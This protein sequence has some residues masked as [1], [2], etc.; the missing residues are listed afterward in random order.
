MGFSFDGFVLRPPRIS[1]VNSKY[2]GEPDNGVIRVPMEVPPVYDISGTSPDFIDAYADQYRAAVLDGPGSSPQE[3]LF[4]AQN[5][6]QLAVADDPSW[7]TELGQGTFPAGS[8]SVLDTTPAPQKPPLKGAGWF[9]DGTSRVVVADDGGR[10]LGAILWLVVARGDV[11]DYDD[12]GWVDPDNPASPRAGDNPYLAFEIATGDQ[13]PVAGTADLTAA[14]LTLLDGG[15]SQERGD[16]IMGV[17]YTVGTVK[18]W[19]TR[20]DRYETRFGWSDTTQRWEPYKGS[21]PRDLGRLYLDQTYKMDPKVANLPVNSELPGTS[22]VDAY[23][24]IRLGPSPS[25][26]L[27]VEDIVVRPNTEVAGG[28]DFTAYP[29]F[30]AV[31]G[32]TNGILE[33]NP[34]FAEQHAGKTVWYCFKTFT[35][36]DEGLVGQL[37]DALTDPLFLSPIPGPT[38]RPL[39]RLGNR[40]Y[41][42]PTLLDT[43]AD[44]D[45]HGDPA[46]GEVSVSLS[47][48][49]IR[50]APGDMAKSDP[51]DAAAFDKHF[52]GEDVIYDGVALNQVPQ[53]TKAPVQLV[54]DAG[55][56]S[57]AG[58]GDLFIPL[59]VTLPNDNY[60]TD[61]TR[62]GLG[63]SGII[64]APDET[65][66]LPISPGTVPGIRPGGD[67]LTG[68]WTGMVRQVEDGVGDTIIF[69]T[70]SA[71]QILVVDREQDLPDRS[72]KVAKGTAYVSRQA[73]GAGTLSKVQ[74]S[75]DDLRDW[76]GEAVYFLQASLT[77]ATYTRLPRVLS[78]NRDLFRFD[79]TEILYFNVDT[80]DYT[81]LASALPAASF[82]TPDQVA[83]SINTAITGTGSAYALNGRLVIEGDDTVEIG[84]GTATDKDLSGAAILGFMPGWR[85]QGGTTNWLTDSGVS[86]GLNRSPVNMARTNATPDLAAS[87]RM[88]DRTLTKNIQ[89]TPFFFLDAPPLQDV[90][91]IDDGVF[92]NL[93]SMITEGE[94]VTIVNR[95][96]QH[97]SDIIHRFGQ[98]KFDWVD[99]DSIE[100]NVERSTSVLG[101]GFSN[102]VPESMLG[103][104]GIG[105]G[106]LIS[107]D[108]GPSVFQDSDTDYVL[109]D[110]GISGQAILVERFG[111]RAMSGAQG[112]MTA[113]STTFSD[114]DGDFTNVQPG[115]RLK[116]LS[117]DNAGS[118]VVAEVL[119]GTSLRVSP[120]AL[121]TTSTPVVWSLYEGYTRD[122]YDPSLAADFVYQT[123]NHLPEEPFQ[124]RLLSPLGDVPTDQ[125]N[126]RLKANMEGALESGRP[127]ELRYGLTVATSTNTASLTPLTQ[128]ELGP[129]ANNSLEVPD[130]GSTRFTTEK[131]SI[132]VGTESYYHGALLTGVAS[133]SADPGG[134]SGI[135]YLTAAGSDGDIGLLKFGSNVLVSYATA[136]VWYVEEFSDPSDLTALA[137]EYNPNTGYLN[138]PEADV[139]AWAGTRAYFVER[140]ITEGREDVSLSPQVGTFAFNSPV[141][142]GCAV[143][144]QYWRADLEGRKVGD[145]VVEFLPVP[146]RNEA[147]QRVSD[148]VFYFNTTQNT[149]LQAIDPI[150][151]LGPVQQNFG[152]QDCI[153]DFPT[154]MAGVGRITFLAQTIP[155]HVDVMVSYWVFEAQGGER[156]YETSQKP[157]YRPPFF[158]KE[159]LDRFGLRGDRTADFVAGQLLRFGEDCFYVRA[160]DYWP[161]DDI[162]GIDIFPSTVLEVGTRAPANDV[163][164][165]MT[166]DPVTTIVDPDG[167]T[168]VSTSAPAGFMFPVDLVTFPFEPVSKGQKAIT[169]TGDLTSFAIPGHIFEIGGYPFTISEVGLNDDGTRTKVS[170]TAGFQAAFDVSNSPTVKLSYR[171][172][173]APDTRDIL[174][175]GA[176]L[177]SEESELVVYGESSGGV[178]QPGRTLRPTVDYEIEPSTGNVKLLDPMQAALQPGQSLSLSYTQV[179]TL[180]PF[181]KDGVVAF[182]RY[183]ADFLHTI[184]PDESNGLLGG[185]VTGTYTFRSPDTF[186]FRILTLPS[187]LVEAAGEAVD[188]ITAKRPAGGAIQPPAGGDENWEKGRLGLAGER[189]HLMDKDRAARTFLDFYNSNI[190]A[191]E[192]VGETIN[193]E[194]VGD[195]DGKF[196]FFV[197]HGKDV[198]TPGYEN[199]ITG[200]LTPR[201]VWSEV[202]NEANP[203]LDLWFIED[204]YVVS[205]ASTTMVSGVLQ[206]WMPDS[207]DLEALMVR[208]GALVQNDV[209]DVVMTR[210]GKPDVK[211]IPGL[212]PRFFARA[213]GEFALMSDQH[214]FSRLYPTLTR[215]FML[216]GPGVGAD[217][218][219]GD[220]GVYTW[221]RLIDGEFRRSKGSTIAQ[222]YNPVVEDITGVST[223]SLSNRYARGRVWGYFPDGIPA[224]MFQSGGSLAM[225]QPCI[226][227]FPAP[228]G[229]V[230][231]DPQ[232]GYPDDTQL[233]SQGLGGE[234][235]D[236]ASG[237]PDLVVPGFL[238]GEQIRW[239]QPDGGLYE[240][241]YQ[242]AIDIFGQAVLTGVFVSQVLYGCVLTLADNTGEPITNSNRVLIGT[243]PDAGIPLHQFPVER[244]DT[245]Y[246]GPPLGSQ[247]A[248]PADPVTFETIQTMSEGF[249][250]FRDGFDFDVKE[251]GRIVDKTL[252]SFKDPWFFGLKEMFGQ[253]PPD[254]VSAIGGPVEF[255]YQSQ[256][257]LRV[258]ALNGADKDD[259]G[260]YQIP[261]LRSTN[262]ELDR[263]DELS[264]TMAAVVMTVDGAGNA[265]YPDEIV[266]NDG[267]VLTSPDLDPAMLGTGQ[268][269]QPLANGSLAKGIGD[270]HP[271]DLM[272]IQVDSPSPFGTGG[273][274][275]IH[276]V[277]SVAASAG[278]PSDLEPPRFVTPVARGQNVRHTMENA[279]VYLKG[280]YDGTPQTTLP[281]GC[282]ISQH[283]AS[284]A[285]IMD[286]ASVVAAGDALDLN[287]RL[288]PL[289]PNPLGNLNNIWW[290]DPNNRV[291][292]QLISR[293]DNTILNGPAGG[294]PD[295]WLNP[296]G[297]VALTIILTMT[298]VEVIDY[299]GTSTGP[300]ALG[301]PPES[302]TNFP[303]PNPLPEDNHEIIFYPAVGVIPWGPGGGGFNEWFL[304]YLGTPFYNRMIYGFEF[305]V[306]VDTAGLPMLAGEP[307]SIPPA[308]AGLSTSAA[309]RPDRLVFDESVDLRWAAP[310]GFQHPQSGLLLQTSLLINEVEINHPSGVHWSSINRFC[311]G[312]AGAG[313]GV[314]LT[315]LERGYGTGNWTPATLPG[316]DSGS[317]RAMSFEGYGDQAFTASDVR[318]SGVATNTNIKGGADICTGTGSICSP[319]SIPAISP[320]DVRAFSDRVAGITLGAGALSNIEQGDLLVIDSAPGANPA[321]TKVGTYLVRHAV[322]RD[323][324][325]APG[326]YWR[327]APEITVGGG[328]DWVPMVFPTV[329]AFTPGTLTLSN[330]PQTEYKDPAVV[331]LV[332]GLYWSAFPDS[333]GV[334]RIYIVRNVGDLASA[335]E[336]T[337]NHA[338][339]SAQYTAITLGGG[340]TPDFAVTDYRDASGN[341]LSPADFEALLDKPYPVSGM[342]YLPVNVNGPGLPDDNVA[343]Y[344]NPGAVNLGFEFITL[345]PPASLAAASDL[346]FSAPGGDIVTN[347]TAPNSVGVHEGWMDLTRWNEFDPEE[348]SVRFS[349]V[350]HTLDISSLLLLWPSINVPP[351]SFGFGGANVVGCILPGTTAGAAD[352]SVP[353][354]VTPGHY[355][356]EGIF[357]E[358]SFPRSTVD[359][360]AVDPLVVDSA[361]PLPNPHAQDD[362][363]R[364]VTAR[365]AYY[366]DLSGATVSDPELVSFE[367]R[368]MRRW[369]EIQEDAGSG[370]KPLRYAYEIR[371]GIL[372]GYSGSARQRPTVHAESFVMDWNDNPLHAPFDPKA[373]D[374]WN[375]GQTYTGTNVGPFTDP[376][377]NINA[378]D[379]FRLLGE[380]LSVLEEIEIVGVEGD[381][382]LKLVAP[383]QTSSPIGYRF[384]I[385]LRQAV[386]PHEQSNEQLLELITDRLVHQTDADWSTDAGGY[387]KNTG[388]YGTDANK[389][390]DSKEDLNT[391]GIRKDDI[392]IIDPQ[393]DLDVRGLGAT[394]LNEKGARPLGD[395]GVDGRTSGYD[396]LEPSVYDDNRGYYRVKS[397]IYDAV[398]PHL[399]LEPISTYSGTALTP[400]TFAD[401]DFEY[402]VYPTISGST[403][404]GTG[405]DEGQMDLRPTQARDPISKSFDGNQF[406]V[407]PFSYKVIR[408]SGLYTNEALD[409]VLMIRERMLSII[410]MFRA[411]LNGRK[412][413]NF[414]VFQRDEHI[415]DVGH[416]TD[417]EDGMGV[418]SNAY[419]QSLVGE[420]DFQPYLNNSGCLSM[421]DR[422]FWIHDSKLDSLT[423][424]GDGFSM[425]LLSQ[426]PPGP[427]APVPY[428]AY[429]DTSPGGGGE[430]LPVEPER[431]DLVLDTSDKFRPV[432]YVWLA[433]RTHKVLGTIASLRRFDEELPERLA[434]AERLILL[435]ETV[436]GVSDE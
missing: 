9:Y 172:I 371:R 78:R 174:G 312:N 432:R 268:D 143:E 260:D 180:Q 18:M 85:V 318:F 383:I 218:E 430:V 346:P 365:E 99:D 16:Q 83:A 421:L 436:E 178:T 128:A 254:P 424:V 90:A 189:R 79:G 272:L 41:L 428:T 410:E 296:G 72:Y 205:P 28:F 8:L 170:V 231:V 293:W 399:V 10:S 11:D 354:T 228:L 409:L 319:L 277:G 48:G 121:A 155:A 266:A 95:P 114:P 351:G 185:R 249:D 292:I 93:Q 270:V 367:I 69:A 295:P 59:A 377:V 287:D 146:V 419:L 407:Q 147:A 379:T 94:S 211:F 279:M 429:T 341:P 177:E 420:V 49:R 220:N 161:D 105:G 36:T 334:V 394:D 98:R 198:P 335:D 349:N 6:A 66:A 126:N 258:P 216:T 201:N 175:L 397:V 167:Q 14:Q 38:D 275:G 213:Q 207:D 107:P 137:A 246:V 97:Y 364:S 376:D 284:G 389:L 56:P 333:A 63:V 233:L 245:V 240:V 19:W 230:P 369:H 67:T 411:M 274:M 217:P 311:N 232:T 140:M 123:F 314:P 88:E 100:G 404:P 298:T 271:G 151:Y 301:F 329:E 200:A 302:G 1:P 366:Y 304:P 17:R 362:W 7:W 112:A 237:D 416:P 129:V 27:P 76:D 89:A 413:G 242:Q 310:R 150:V 182:P 115:Y 149:V 70:Q 179:R 62:R 171:P 350:V 385:Y 239:G 136:P 374:V 209:D 251:D 276:A 199:P 153:I 181:L 46:E 259:S 423:G 206:G 118:Y 264:G 158:I 212:P 226:V 64:N 360:G 142:E 15:L 12:E 80:V 2:T 43:D 347:G 53:P 65:G 168:P 297:F 330:L 221:G 134:G 173:Y 61:L 244:G 192:Q 81:W 392:V 372:T 326:P 54:D 359:L 223:A 116:V 307:I 23:A 267:T 368:R 339:I 403:L 42:T 380:D 86:L 434:E 252:P 82:Y 117:G 327:S 3:Y 208:Q 102:I 378:G 315:F 229:E 324:L 109:P 187:F 73:H 176:L 103:A 305:R 320:D 353:G 343:G 92:F 108:G 336:T 219:N 148:K 309:I 325:A 316:E 87:D 388:A 235:V 248:G 222:L 74:L 111:A 32:Q 214:R 241:Y 357:L 262:T 384:E 273:P 238:E 415:I 289:A 422:R 405:G 125:V 215:A 375:D 159:N 247:D 193:G 337:F 426:A 280:P 431:V 204:D 257:P 210:T 382:L 361:R 20:N 194:F 418:L 156:A 321:C 145:E 104:P 71:A 398:E 58:S 224:G 406:S 373:P 348:D 381:G 400:V 236:A 435:E 127:I 338:V 186:Y 110:D 352:Y 317:L 306:H 132:R 417:F 197:G 4:W 370:F 35:E 144:A 165:V 202:F 285:V 340:T 281:P 124:V 68:V 196:R 30:N 39:L 402:A 40:T 13:N 37:L 120:A 253:K 265:V 52:F 154:D 190:V 282:R 164:S 332:D 50:L 300:V 122:V 55:V 101:F 363:E 322:D 414:Y 344:H 169:F 184:L 328:G 34:S 203:N 84:W 299:Q 96:L 57:T 152:T 5:T 91:G 225:A 355:A 358:P 29:D 160:V 278:G 401:G 141:P 345:R 387:V 133:F 21:S 342:V 234:V 191:F 393:G 261:Y 323:T 24:M 286:F 77:P 131:F 183:S 47:T 390:Y 283:M 33:F 163:I 75:R 255:V 195:R 395:R 269:V 106:F 138:L 157:V 166:L 119:T 331:E 408:P 433:Y 162:T 113:G 263:F 391:A 22:V 25:L 139:T 303:A 396:P 130:T 44:Q 45:A 250:T 412:Y 256:N 425:Q 60:S 294:N 291:V 386:V 313:T 31:M 26:A 188:D 356:Q 288:T 135:E 427:P 290:A 243:A 227:A 51:D 308:P